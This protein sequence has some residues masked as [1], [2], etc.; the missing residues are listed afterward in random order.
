MNED[1]IQCLHPQGK[2]APAIAATTYH[3]FKRAITKTLA[4]EPL[5]YSLIAASVKEYFKK[6]KI[7]FEGSVGWYTET[8]KLD[9]EATGLI[10]AYMKKGK[11]LHKLVSSQ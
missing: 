6:E 4:K 7:A 9:M 5:S 11:K 1:K 2:H 8:I 3:L 10:I